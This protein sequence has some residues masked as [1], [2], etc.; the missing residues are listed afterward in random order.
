[1][2]FEENKK[3][4]LQ[5]AKRAHARY[6][7]IGRLDEAKGIALAV[8]IIGSSDSPVEALQALREV[9]KMYNRESLYNRNLSAHEILKGLDAVYNSLFL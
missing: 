8:D 7:K 6:V 1:M 5:W 9:I 2:I 4:T 3:L